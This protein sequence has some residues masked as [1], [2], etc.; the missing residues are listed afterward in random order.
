MDIPTAIT[1]LTVNVII[2]SIVIILVIIAVIILVV[3]LNK[4]A[5]SVQQTTTH[6]ARIT[7][8]LS[9]AKVFSELVKVFSRKR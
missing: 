1:L 2:L 6:I 9:P 4:I 8:W 5:D 7:E 3:K